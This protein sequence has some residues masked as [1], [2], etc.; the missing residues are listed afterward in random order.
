MILYIWT[1]DKYPIIA[2]AKLKRNLLT[3]Q[4][5]CCLWKLKINNKKTVYSIFTLSQKIARK[6]L[7]LKIDG[8][9]LETEDNPVYLGVKLDCRMTLT[10]H[11]ENT[12][13]KAVKRLNIIKRLATTNWGAKKQMLRQ[14]Y[15]GYVRAVIMDYNLPLQTIESKGAVLSLD[16]VQNQ[17]LRLICGVIP[18]TPTAA[19]EIDANIKPRDLT[20]KR[21]LIETVERYRRQEPDHLNRKLIETWKPVGR[22]QLKTL[23]DVA[24]EMSS[25]ENLP[26]ERELERKSQNVPP[27]QH[28]HQP[29]IVTS[30]YKKITKEAEPNIFKLCAQET[31][32]SYSTS[33]IHAYTD[34]SA[35][36]AT[37]NAGFGILLKYPDGSSFEYS[38]SCGTNCSNYEAEKI[39]IK[40]AIQLI[41][42]Q[43]ELSESN[44][45]DVI[46]FSDAKSALEA[47]QN[48]PYQDK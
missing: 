17:A 39:A 28:L 11:L 35:F 22:I 34:G 44:P 3:L 33:A 38:D 6:T 7:E 46:I 2:K 15:M 12:K 29:K 47:L 43:F 32:N 19:C 4:T 48:P 36:K 18:T 21:S 31:V 5:Y 20:R 42:Q 37:I 8:E 40:T 41:H 14:L 1:T 25:M 24:K 9:R 45:T 23:L 30:L 26:T 13:R 10:E 27:W 16:K